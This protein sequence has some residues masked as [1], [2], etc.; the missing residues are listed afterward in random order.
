M[1]EFKDRRWDEKYDNFMRLKKQRMQL[2]ASKSKITDESRLDS[3]LNKK[4]S[5]VRN[6][7]RKFVNKG[8]SR[9]LKSHLENTQ[10]SNLAQS[11]P[12]I[13]QFESHKEEEKSIPQQIEVVQEEKKEWGKMSLM[14]LLPYL[15]I[16]FGIVVLIFV[17]TKG[18]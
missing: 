7:E 17:L 6:E 8:P 9:F 12:V 2:E 16:I 1:G 11:Q 4:G 3:E 5:V 13:N 10:K 15:F 14:D 18:I